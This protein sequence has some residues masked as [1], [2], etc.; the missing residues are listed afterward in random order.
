MKAYFRVLVQYKQDNWAKFL[1]IAEFTYNN[2]KNTSMTYTLFELN[3]EYYSCIFYKKNVDYCSMS[4]AVDELPK[5]LEI[6]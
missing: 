5:N 6:L 4:K 2:V 3:F 1:L